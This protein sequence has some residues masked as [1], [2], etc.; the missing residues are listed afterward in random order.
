MKDLQNFSRNL[1]QANYLVHL[2]LSHSTFCFHFQNPP[3]PDNTSEL[4]LQFFNSTMMTCSSQ[5]SE[6]NKQF[7]CTWEHQQKQILEEILMSSQQQFPA[8]DFGVKE[9]VLQGLADGWKIKSQGNAR[10][11]LTK[12]TIKM[13][14]FLCQNKK[15]RRKQQKHSLKDSVNE[16]RPNPKKH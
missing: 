11:F 10:L 16:N 12:M 15:K 8:G 6:D 7:A 14:I 4:F 13:C 3:L 2:L 1:C 5:G 9:R